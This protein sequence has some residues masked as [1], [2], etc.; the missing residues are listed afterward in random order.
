MR[1]VTGTV[2]SNKMNK[3]IVVTTHYYK[4]HPKYQKKYR[5]S[6]KF[7]A[8]DEN[9]QYKIGDEVTIYETKPLSKLKCWTVETPKTVTK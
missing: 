5:V 7:Y 6:K 8:H 3:T 9:G 4:T 2:T 1:S